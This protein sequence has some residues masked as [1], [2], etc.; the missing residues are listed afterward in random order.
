MILRWSCDPLSAKRPVVNVCFGGF[1]RKSQTTASVC[2]VADALVGSRDAD[3]CAFSL[4]CASSGLLRRLRSGY[5]G[6]MKVTC[7]VCNTDFDTVNM[8]YSVKIVAWVE[9]L[10]GKYI[11]SPKHPSTPLGYA[12]AVCV[13]LSRAT[14]TPPTL[15]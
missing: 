7:S 13:D 5:H 8:A 9:H 1:L 14:D 11:G 6:R 4:F 2:W 10:N 15:F 3:S 12:H